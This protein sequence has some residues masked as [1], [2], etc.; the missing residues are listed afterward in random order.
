MNVDTITEDVC[1]ICSAWPA[2]DREHRR[3]EYFSSYARMPL[4]GVCAFCVWE[5]WKGIMVV[6]DSLEEL[7]A[8]RDAVRAERRKGSLRSAHELLREIRAKP[9]KH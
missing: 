6:T 4:E 1:V 5:F 8:L 2:E 7:E 3:S 9:L